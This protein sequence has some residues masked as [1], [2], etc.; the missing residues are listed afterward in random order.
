MR[1]IFICL[2]G[3]FLHTSLWAASTLVGQPIQTVIQQKGQPNLMVHGRNGNTVYIYIV[4]TSFNYPATAMGPNPG[5][6]IAPGGK[7]IGAAI[8]RQGGSAPAL[9]CVTTYQVN[10]QGI[11]VSVESQGSCL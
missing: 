5:V 10:K 6:L 3:L 2:I 7:A 9:K 1:I 4:Q 8:P 11:I